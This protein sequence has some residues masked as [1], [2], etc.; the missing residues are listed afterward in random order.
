[1]EDA[2]DEE[3]EEDA[4]DEDT[5]EEEMSEENTPPPPSGRRIAMQREHAVEKKPITVDEKGEPYGALVAAFHADLRALARDL[6]PNGNFVEQTK[7][8]KDRFFKRLWQGMTW[9]SLQ[10][11]STLLACYFLW[12]MLCRKSSVP[13]RQHYVTILSPSML[14]FLVK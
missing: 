10:K 12:H 6:D 1:L 13:A 7:A 3:E 9:L 2:D 5:E 14:G 11:P 8:T 4:E